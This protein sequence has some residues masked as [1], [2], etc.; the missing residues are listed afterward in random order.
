MQGNY[1]KLLNPQGCGLGKRDGRGSVLGSSSS[2]PHTKF[3]SMGGVLVPR[4][5]APASRA[6]HR[7]R[8]LLQRPSSL[9]AWISS[10]DKKLSMWVRRT[11]ARCRVVEALGSGR[12]ASSAMDYRVPAPWRYSQHKWRAAQTSAYADTSSPNRD[13]RA[14]SACRFCRSGDCGRLCPDR[15]VRLPRRGHSFRAKSRTERR[16]AGAPGL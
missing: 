7:Y 16:F 1:V 3:H 10:I 14:G 13:Q 11:S 9:G 4:Q 12:R 8:E 2:R 6:A 5:E 15:Y